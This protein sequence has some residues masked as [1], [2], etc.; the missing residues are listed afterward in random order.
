MVLSFEDT[1]LFDW[2]KKNRFFLFALV[3]LVIGIQGFQYFAP[4]LKLKKQTESW[5]LFDAITADFTTDFDGNLSA[6]LA[7]AKDYPIIYPPIVFTATRVA[8]IEDNANALTTLKPVLEDLVAN[9][10]HWRTLSEAGEMN[11]I[12]GELLARVK[13]YQATGGVQLENPEPTGTKVKISV[14]SSSGKT[15]DVIAG[16]YEDLAPAACAAFL[17]AVENEQ[18]NGLEL[19]AF[20]SSLAFKDFNPDAEE[21]LP[22]ERR[23][24]LFHLAGSLSTSMMPGE[25]SKQVADSVVIYLQD[26]TN[27]DGGSSVFG[28]LTEGLE[29]LQAALAVPQADVTY[30][31]TS[32]SVL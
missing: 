3:L 15:Y 11:S 2:L 8:L 1:P 28:S 5:M 18:L 19:T 27:V 6:G 24:G 10:G 25:P 31:I 9:A 20:A 26:S 7:Q 17:A 14:T 22:L 21:G 32:A 23:F 4:A 16:L 12:A 30:S 29:P 13:D